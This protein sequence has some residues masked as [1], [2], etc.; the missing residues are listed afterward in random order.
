MSVIWVLPR[1]L[2]LSLLTTSGPELRPAW[3]QLLYTFVTNVKSTL[4]GLEGKGEIVAVNNIIFRAC[5]CFV[6]FPPSSQIFL[7]AKEH[8]R[9]SGRATGG[10]SPTT[11]PSSPRT[12]T[13][14]PPWA[15]RCTPGAGR[16]RC[17]RSWR[18]S[19]RIWSR[20]W[21]KAAREQGHQIGCLATRSAQLND[22]ICTEQ[23]N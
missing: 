3:A 7:Q 14:T 4:A 21:C 2:P 23:T 5:K 9:A 15:G 13:R 11:R 12:E 20:V 10:R 17:R 1:R 19:A 18:C 16:R 8:A 6:S 22:S